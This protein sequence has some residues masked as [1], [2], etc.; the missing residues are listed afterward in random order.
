MGLFVQVCEFFHR[1]YISRQV[2]TNGMISIGIIHPQPLW[3][4]DLRHI[5]ARGVRIRTAEDGSG[6]H[7]TVTYSR[8]EHLKKG[9]N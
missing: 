3:H 1:V 8:S 4:K 9:I 2:S 6:S 7:T 5:V